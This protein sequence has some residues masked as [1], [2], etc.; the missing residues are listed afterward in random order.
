MTR[1]INR[2]R[3]GTLEMM[4]RKVQREQKEQKETKVH[5]EMQVLMVLLD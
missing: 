5:T 1:L 2:E 4:D 3:E